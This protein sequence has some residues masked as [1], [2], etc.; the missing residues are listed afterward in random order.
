MTVNDFIICLQEALEAE[1][2]SIKLETLLQDHPNWDSLSA[3]AVMSLI[4]SEFN[5]TVPST[6]LKQKMTVQELI[7]YLRNLGS[8]IQ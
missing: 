4:D 5:L 2:K 7:D 1:S 6:I 8:I 3:L